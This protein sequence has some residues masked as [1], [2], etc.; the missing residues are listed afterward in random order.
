MIIVG[1][2]AFHGDSSACLLR[3]G[4]LVAAVEEERF[5][6]IKHWAGFPALSIAYCLREAGLQ[7]ADVDFVAINSHASAA[8]SKK[9]Q[10][11]LS[12]RAGS[13]LIKG[14]IVDP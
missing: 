4:V 11:L 7:L 3:D 2:N 13:A 10:F 8:R 1:L 5:T 9:L 12:G 14:K 6:R